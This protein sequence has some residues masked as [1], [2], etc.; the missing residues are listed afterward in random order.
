MNSV[1]PDHAVIRTKL[2]PPPRRAQWLR[3]ERLFELIRSGSEQRLTVIA[4]P[5]GSGKTT[6]LSAWCEADAEV[7]PAAWL[8]LDDAD[9]DPVVLWAHAIEAL[10]SLH[11]GLS[12]PPPPVGPAGLVNIV[13]PRLVN[14][15]AQEDGGILILDDFQRLSRGE[16]RE[17]VSW[18]LDH[19]PPGFRLIVATRHEPALPVARFRARGD[20]LEIRA[21]ELTFTGDEAEQF[22]NGR[23]GLALNRGDVD[24][25]VTR[26]DGWAA[27][28]Y[29]A[30]LSL[31]G[32]ADRG[33]LVDEFKAS[34]RHMID[35]LLAEVIEAHDP[36]LQTLMLRASI[37]DRICG[38]LCDAV[39]DGEGGAAR[40]DELATSNLFL[41]PLDDS[42]TW[43]RF[44]QLFVRLLRVELERREPGLAP[45]LHRRAYEW[46][47]EHG[48][49]DE[50][51][52]HAIEAGAI[53]E[54]SDL[55]A[56]VWP[57]YVNACRHVTV[58]EWLER[59]GPEVV[60]GDRRLQLVRAWVLSF[61]GRPD[62]AAA[63][64]EAVER[65]GALEIGPLPDGLHS[66]ESSLATLRAVFPGG[67][68]GLQLKNALRAAELEPPGSPFRCV[69]YWAIGFGS[70]FHGDFDRAAASFEEC[71][72][73]APDNGQ[74]RVAGSALA[75]RSLIAGDRGLLAEQQSL[76]EQA[77]DL[78][79]EHAIEEIDGEAPLALGVS[80]ATRGRA[81]EALPLIDRSVEI[82]R[83]WGQPLDLA[84]A[85]LRRT[86]VLRELG[87]SSRA[88]ECLD[89]AHTII[90][91]CADPGIL[92]ER[93]ET[94]ADE[95]GRSAA[96]NQELTARELTVL[97]LL[98][99]TLSEREIGREL[100]LSHNT[101]H[102]HT[103]AIYR[104]LGVSSRPEAVA[105]ARELRL[106]SRS[107]ST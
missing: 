29:L 96:D 30:A 7:T 107:T 50:A 91:G 46:H 33:A 71:S 93:L 95:G 32:V 5:A 59:L 67:D 40:L 52:H 68:I 27:G 66:L 99:G 14:A 94:L 87:D 104:K 43:Y 26:T 74:W 24:T 82:L 20:L 12:V 37:L 13:L 92:R 21:D 88:A 102:T 90:D 78:V 8:T 75:Y 1:A 65:A 85:L 44:H 45:V 64:T 70:Y 83:S 39:L 54:S 84:K 6:L 16:A 23:L 57:S 41:I 17:S 47:R 98:G 9:N 42:G 80:L 25:L 35:F 60:A 76:A 31:S 69:A 53:H 19:A 15:L 61:A 3:R 106:P 48:A 97:R 38:A 89:E 72:S 101:V 36:G 10:R 51:V 77:D 100:Y 105:R 34:N 103:K 79:R 2:Y 81:D 58:L 11:P 18:F 73:L 28:L 86:V 49:V 4:A 62:E 56:E 63:C 22:L 55:I